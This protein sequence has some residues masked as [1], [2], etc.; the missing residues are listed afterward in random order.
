MAGPTTQDEFERGYNFYRG[1]NTKEGDAKALEVGRQFQAWQ[2]AQAN[3]PRQPVQYD[4]MKS[5]KNFLPSLGS[6]V[7]DL[8]SAISSPIDTSKAVANLIASGGANLLQEGV[9][10]TGSDYQVPNQDAGEEFAGML[11]ERYGSMDALK[12][13]AMND[14]AG[15]LMDLSSV[16]TGGGTAVAKTGGRLSS[17]VKAAG[18]SVANFGAKLDP[19]TGIIKAPVAAFESMTGQPVSRQ[20]YQQAMK[21]SNTIRPNKKKQLLDDG[22]ELG[23]TPTTRSMNKVEAR[24]QQVFNEIESIEAGVNASAT[25]P[26]ARLFDHVDDVKNDYRP[27]ILNSADALAAIDKVVDAQLESLYHNGGQRLTVADLARIKRHIYKN[28]SWDKKVGKNQ[29]DQPSQ[30]TMKAIARSAKEMI[31]EIVPDVKV[32]NDEYGKIANVQE[33]LQ[34]PAGGRSGNNNIL[35]IGAPIATATGAAVAGN[36]GAFIGGSIGV[37]DMA[38]PKALAAIGTNRLG[39]QVRRPNNYFKTASLAGRYEQAAL[40]DKEEREQERVARENKRKDIL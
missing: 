3:A 23:A 24:K 18:E 9:N 30:E 25:S 29:I 33:K 14:P 36:P 37:L 32:L 12:T 2:K 19:L 10:L 7:S 6:A 34:I 26:P 20:L 31:E 15:L 21:P 4:P 1:L 38:V 11:D 27:P 22:L 8:G 13:T 40:R 16:F 35:G 17:K 39:K 5:V 28:V